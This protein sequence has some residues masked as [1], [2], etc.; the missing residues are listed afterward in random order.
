MRSNTLLILDADDTLWESA[1]FFERTEHDFLEL[2]HS[3]GFEREPI[4]NIV[5]SRDIARLAVTG[6]GARPYISTLLQILTELIPEVPSWVHATFRDIKS[7]LLEHPVILMP[8]VVE[9]LHTIQS[10][11][12][13]TV[14]YTMGEQEHQHNKFMRSGLEQLVDGIRI[15]SEKTVANLE[16][17]ITHYNMTPDR[18]IL[19]GNSP[20]SDINP[21][22]SLG[23][24][25]VHIVRDRT[26]AAERE[27]FIN[28]G[29]VRTIERFNEL[30]DIL[31]NNIHNY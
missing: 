10:Q 5:H 28:P 29:L 9:T 27:D 15:V 16:D 7:A 24:Q 3:L 13:T 12:V 1:L 31:Q 14:V 8:G 30:L 17:L 18:C 25:A 23:I 22:L 26:W 6:Y 20:R 11:P 2:M 21:A 19:V 4:R